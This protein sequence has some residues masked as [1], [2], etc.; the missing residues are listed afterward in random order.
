MI[1]HNPA[2]RRGKRAEHAA[3]SG[4]KRRTGEERERSA[5][6]LTR[7]YEPGSRT[8]TSRMPMTRFSAVSPTAPARSSSHHPTQQPEF[9]NYP[10]ET[11]PRVFF[12]SGAPAGSH[13]GTT[14]RRVRGH[15]WQ[16]TAA[17]AASPPPPAAPW[18]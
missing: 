18:G 14:G 12:S 7:R 11:L 16:H 13:S 9:L 1:S 4:E 3:A 17:G 15:P 8:V 2:T 10:K 6:A 5:Q